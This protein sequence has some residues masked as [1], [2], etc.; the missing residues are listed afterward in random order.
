MP[1]ISYCCHFYGWQLEEC[2]KLPL[3]SIF[4]FH[5][6]GKKLEAIHYRELL[7]IQ[8]VSIMN[9]E[10][11]DWIKEIYNGIIDPKSKEL[12]QRPDPLPREGMDLASP[13]TK[14]KIIDFFARGKRGLGYGR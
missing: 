8:A 2:L 10:Y 1:I 5:R 14:N 11:Y 13:D 12:P 7:R 9:L 6:E 4:A 3:K